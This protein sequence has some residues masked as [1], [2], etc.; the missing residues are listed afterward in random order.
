ML[1]ITGKSRPLCDSLTRRRFIAVGSLGFF[2]C[3]LSNL[4]AAEST[5][6]RNKRSAIL[7]WQHG[8]PSQLDTFDL[9]PE[10][11]SEVRG[12]YQSIATTLPGVRISELMPYHAK[13]MDKISVVRSFTHGT[14]D[15]FAGA[16]WILS[17]YFG[18]TGGNKVPRNPSMGSVATR[19]LKSR[20]SGI[21]TY[22]NINDGGF[23]YHGAAFLG[24]AYNPINMG[25]YS[26]GREGIQFPAIHESNLKLIDGL[27]PQRA[28][29]RLSLAGR[30]D[31]LRRNLDKSKEVER[32]D[33]FSRQAIEIVT[34]GRTRD[35]MDL[36]KED[37]AVRERYGDGWGAQALMARRLIEAGS[38][39][40]TL[41]T[42]YWDDHG[43]IKNALDSKMPGH[44]R[45]VG[46]L[47]ADL[48]E[49]GMLEDTLVISAGEFGRTPVINKDAGRDHWGAA[50]SILLAGGGYRHG[51]M[52]GTTDAKAAYP[53]DSPMGPLDLCQTVYRSLNLDP[54][55]LTI[56][57]ADGRPARLATGGKVPHELL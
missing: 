16:H 57:L 42:G 26:Y 17:G 1:Y 39:F 20:Q 9:K 3:T 54:E 50:Q 15:H 37:P 24:T 41:N 7:I 31:G 44:D 25:S 5:G 43:N 40:V 48:A 34:S 23:G 27:S 13:V 22:V 51:Q 28:G 45:A 2:G 56:K 36:E 11:A 35:A 32:L 29:D 6:Q 55:Q 53:A 52:I 14:N 38:R 47:I 10:A 30:L 49:R 4:L 18:A 19:F 8:G 12:P 33:H 21:P 46:V